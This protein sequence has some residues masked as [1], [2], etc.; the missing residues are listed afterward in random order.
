M[1]ALCAEEGGALEMPAPRSDGASAHSP[2]DAPKAA[3]PGNLSPF[4]SPHW[5]KHCGVLVQIPIPEGRQESR[6]QCPSLESHSE[7]VRCVR[8]TAA[9]WAPGVGARSVGQPGCKPSLSTSWLHGFEQSL[10]SLS[11]C[12]PER[13]EWFPLQVTVRIH[14]ATVGTPVPCGRGDPGWALCWCHRV[15]AGSQ[16]FCREERD[17]PIPGNTAPLC[18]EGLVL[19]PPSAHQAL[20]AQLGAAQDP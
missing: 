7:W 4:P 14:E 19:T 2:G 6:A 3:Q 18:R 15:E 8:P 13:D 1:G 9:S 20:H 10:M 12:L 5:S 11:L 17:L 16:P